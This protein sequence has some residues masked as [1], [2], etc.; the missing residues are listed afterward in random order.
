MF[1]RIVAVNMSV[2]RIQVYNAFLFK[3]VTFCK[4]YAYQRLPF[5]DK[6]AIN[7]DIMRKY[8]KRHVVESMSICDVIL[9]IVTVHL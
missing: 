9:G 2:L 4:E 3:T 8:F 7:L 5:W 1:E 6:V